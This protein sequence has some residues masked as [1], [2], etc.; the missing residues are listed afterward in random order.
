MKSIFLFI[1]SSVFSIPATYAS[2]P[3][4]IYQTEHLII[5]QVSENV[6]EH[7]T[8]LSTQDFGKVSCN[9][10][11]V[12]DEHETIVFDTTVDNESSEEL[13]NWINNT[14]K[15]EVKAVVITH[16]HSD[17]L[18][19]I[20][21]FTKRQI[22]AYA[23]YKTIEF[24]LENEVSFPAITFPDSLTLTVG[25]K[26]IHTAFFGEGHTRDNVVA[27]FPAEKALFGGCLVKEMNAGKGNLADANEQA[28]SETVL[29]IKKAYPDIMIVIPGHGKTGTKKLLDYTIRLF[30]EQ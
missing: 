30:K 2:K 29:K 9:G 23:Y 27:Y 13:I 20:E 25:T 8:F 5:T 18:G 15:C 21:A 24:A 4:R 12:R 17:C 19:G 6:F 3:I 14:L 28:W 10:M 16:F 1:I 11:I 26:A 22:P 7:T